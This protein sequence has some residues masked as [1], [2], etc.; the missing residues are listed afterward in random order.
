[1][2]S[3]FARILLWFIATLTVTVAGLLLTTAI[4]VHTFDGERG[5]VLRVLPFIVQEAQ[6]S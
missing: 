3:L 1:M 4:W 5:P 2:K 6:M